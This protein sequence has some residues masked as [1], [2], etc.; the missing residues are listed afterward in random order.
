ML[1]K[2]IARVVTIRQFETMSTLS[3]LGNVYPRTHA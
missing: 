2:D 1:L 3:K